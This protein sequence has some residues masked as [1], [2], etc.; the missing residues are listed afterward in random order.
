MACQDPGGSMET[1]WQSTG[2]PL[3][4]INAI[5]MEI[6]FK[7]VNSTNHVKDCMR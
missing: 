6:V 3:S 7:Q 4:V 1:L 5:N 2:M